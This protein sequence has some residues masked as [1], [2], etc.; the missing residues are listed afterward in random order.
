M[1]NQQPTR[2]APPVAVAWPAVTDFSEA[3]R[4]RG[5]LQGEARHPYQAIPSGGEFFVAR[6]GASANER[7][8]QNGISATPPGDSLDFRPAWRVGWG[9]GLT[10]LLAGG[11]ALT[12]QD[13][14][15]EMLDRGLGAGVADQISRA[16]PVTP[17]DVVAV[18]ALL[19][20]FLVLGRWIYGRYSRLYRVTHDAIEEIVGIVA[21]QTR[22]VRLQHV[23]SV[24]LQQ[25]VFGRIFNVGTLEF[26]SA[27][28]GEIDV[29]FAGIRRPAIVRNLIHER[30]H[31]S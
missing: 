30:I 16:L 11:V 5:S 20:C 31:R 27:G 9:K 21:I 6:A 8:P 28:T 2:Q 22:R 3:A 24:G 12:A 26:A 4:L 13:F 1:T 15:P 25:T 10:A 29:R 18:A 7:A 17:G 14:V 19:I 23:R